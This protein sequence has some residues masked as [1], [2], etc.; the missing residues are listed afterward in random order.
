MQNRSYVR[1][2]PLQRPASL[3]LQKLHDE[4]PID[5]TCYV[6]TIK[7][8]RALKQAFALGFVFAEVSCA[9]SGALE[10]S[11][12]KLPAPQSPTGKE[13]TNHGLSM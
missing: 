3:S 12:G 4:A 5:H 6:S 13:M 11:V 7:R 1:S 10:Q 2:E 9:G 8:V